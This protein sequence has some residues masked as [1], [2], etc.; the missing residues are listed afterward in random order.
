MSMIVKTIDGWNLCSRDGAD[1]WIRDLE[2]AERAGLVETRQIR[3]VIRGVIHSG[4]SAPAVILPQNTLVPL[5]NGGHQKVTEYLLNREAAL[6]VVMRLR[7]ERAVALQVAIVRVFLAV[8]D[9]E[10]TGEEIRSIREELTERNAEVAMMKTQIVSLDKR[11][12]AHDERAGCISGLAGDWINGEIDRLA[13]KR[14]AA[15]HSPNKQSARMYLLNM[16]R[17]AARWSGPGQS[18]RDMPA[19][20][21]PHVKAA[22]KNE[23]RDLNKALRAAKKAAPRARAGSQVLLFPGTRKKRS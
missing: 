10:L 8:V 13:E 15:N 23:D 16:V 7:T 18:L 20:S 5:A 6:I 17:A 12:T 1:W 9:G 19:S 11:L 21:Y 2:L 14:T 4:L 3:R 22:I